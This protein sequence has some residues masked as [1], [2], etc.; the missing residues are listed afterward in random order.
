MYGECEASMCDASGFHM[1][2][3]NPLIIS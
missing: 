1:G 2:P 3:Q